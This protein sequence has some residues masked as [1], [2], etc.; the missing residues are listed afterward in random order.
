MTNNEL[1]V[2]IERYQNDTASIEEAALVDRWYD[3][4]GAN[5]SIFSI[6]TNSELEQAYVSMFSAITNAIK[7]TPDAD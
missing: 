6:Y 7:I 1:D 3:S 5:P 4:F 2:L